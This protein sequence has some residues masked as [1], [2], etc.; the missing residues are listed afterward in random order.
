MLILSRRPGESLTIGDDVVVTVIGVSG[1]QIRLGIT[2]PRE[3]RVL[4]AEIHQGIR[5]ENQAAANAL[6]S[7]SKLDDA[8]TQL[9]RREKEKS[10][11]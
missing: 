8:V 9:R 7:N 1:N 11:D 2:A 4:R 6:D 3:V 10:S 5:E